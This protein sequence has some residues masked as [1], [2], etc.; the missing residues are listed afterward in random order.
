MEQKL[1]YASIWIWIIRAY[2]CIIAVTC[3]LDTDKNMGREI[4]MKPQKSSFKINFTFPFVSFLS[5][6]NQSIEMLQSISFNQSNFNKQDNLNQ[7]QESIS[8]VQYTIYLNGALSFR[9]GIP[10]T[11]VKS[12]IEIVRIFDILT[13][14]DKSQ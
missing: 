5:N 1:K 8:Y 9:S 2:V 10:L 13:T 6:F 4:V 12:F 3:I 14:N 11:P 7:F